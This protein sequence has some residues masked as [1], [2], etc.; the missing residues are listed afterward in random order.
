MRKKVLIILLVLSLSLSFIGYYIYTGIQNRNK[1]EATYIK[2]ADGDK[3]GI[4][5]NGRN[6]YEWDYMFDNYFEHSG[7]C[8]EDG[9]PYVLVKHE[10]ER[11]SEFIYIKQDKFSD[12]VFFKNDYFGYISEF[13]DKNRDFIVIGFD[14][15]ERF[16][17]ENFVFPTIDNNIVNEVWMSHS[18]DYEIIKDKETVD[19]IVECAKSDGKIKLDKSIVGYIK[20]HSSDRHCLWLKYEGYPIIEEFHIEETEDGRYIVAQYAVEDYYNLYWQDEAHQ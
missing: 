12:Y 17:D 14:L 1:C 4:S 2:N 20:K 8:A 9:F 11:K 13:Y 19:K 10:D 18:D 5:Y 6:Y 3:I 7:A 15:P 16:V